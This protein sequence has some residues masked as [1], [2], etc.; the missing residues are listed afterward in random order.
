MITVEMW[1]IE[2]PGQKYGG[3]VI[4]T[5]WLMT[6]IGFTREKCDS[7]TRGYRT[8]AG[9]RTNQN[10]VVSRG[11]TGEPPSLDGR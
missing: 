4:G 10:Y 7:E 11:T 5:Y 2:M 9:K 8:K 3:G 6:R 1:T